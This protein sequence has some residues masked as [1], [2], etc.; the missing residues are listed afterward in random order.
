MSSFHLF[1]SS[2]LQSD[3]VGKM[4]FLALFATSIFTWALIIYKGR[5]IK[6]A[7]VHR[8]W[9]N[10]QALNS[11]ALTLD[12]P[13]KLHPFAALYAHIQRESRALLRKNN[14]RGLSKA[15]IEAIASRSLATVNDEVHKL[16]R[17]LFIF[18]LVVGL[19]PF[20]GLLGTVWGIL[21]SFSE[22]QM[23]GGSMREVVLS[24]LA[25]ALST[26]VFGLIVAIPA[27]IAN[28]FLGDN[29][30][31]IDHELEQQFSEI[32]AAIELQYRGEAL[33][34]L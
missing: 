14:G 4:I 16:S 7:S 3:T 33:H 17:Y 19:A 15:D 9:L 5:E 22:M 27:L 13:K 2:Y 10:R 8:R 1:L 29:L 30:R 28:S 31:E 32:M 34:A 23:A 25:T 24:G 12:L 11:G 6:R 18:P 20:L 26:T 21:L